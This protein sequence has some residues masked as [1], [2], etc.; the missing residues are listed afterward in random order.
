MDGK[1]SLDVLYTGFDEQY[2]ADV[3]EL[4]RLIA[5]YKALVDA[6]NEGLAESFFE[7]SESIHTLVEK[8][9]TY[10]G[11]R[12]AADTR[13]SEAMAYTGRLMARLSE[14][15]APE[16]AVKQRIAKLPDLDKQIE[17][18]PLLQQYSYFIGNLVKDSK[19]L[20]A[21][22][23]ERIVAEMDI[24]GGDAWSQL[25]SYVTSTVLCDY[26]GEKIGL[27]AVR[28][29]AYDP[30]PSVRKDAYEAEL[31]A[32]K[33]IQDPVAFSLNSIKLQCIN[34]SK[35]RG[36]ESPLS[37]TLYENRMKK[38]TL[39]A[40]LSAMRDY[41]PKFREYMRAKGKALGHENGLPWY[42]MFAP[43]GK[44]DRKFSVS[45]SKDVLL[46][47]FGRFDKQ[48][49]DMMERAYDEDWI[50]FFPREGKTGG[51]FCCSINSINQS[52]ILT[53]FDGSFSDICTLAHELGHA[54]HNQMLAGH[55]PL[56]MEYCMPLAETAS[57]FNE[58]VLMDKA[59][60]TAADA[61]EKLAFIEG[62]LCDANQ[63]ICDIYSRYLFETAVFA[64]RPEEFMMADKLC[65]LMLNAQREAYSDGLDPDALHP[66]MWVCK[67]HYYSAGLS[68][69][70]FPYAFGGLFARGLYAKYKTEGDAFIPQYKKLLHATTVMDVEQTAAIAGIDLTDKAFWA[71]SLQSI[72]DEIDEFIALVEDK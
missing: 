5:E 50:D 3:A 9:Y 36:F 39:D 49:A 44:S 68:F 53:N 4:D 69:Y 7:L 10:P 24:S 30:D 25:Q 46:D 1:W 28:N 27:S 67:S 48:L 45:D 29:L 64:A 37:R 63:I 6:P 12:C 20:L 15:A 65:E 40:L 56:N 32:Y 38:E 2:K 70:N 61:D 8:L 58:N 57:T 43:M 52:R 31:S 13:D 16:A 66:Y 26:R 17:A 22:R 71:M 42:D 55:R 47:L 54:F 33:Q 62:Q 21:P 51:A 59:I 41:M 23:E 34:I 35:L 18:S 11:L 72:A 19:H 60:V 14:L